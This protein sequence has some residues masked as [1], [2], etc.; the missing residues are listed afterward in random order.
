MQ[1]ARQPMYVEP[2]SMH[3][4][5][6]IKGTR[7]WLDTDSFIPNPPC[8]M[9]SIQLK[10]T[11]HCALYTVHEKKNQGHGYYVLCNLAH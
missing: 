9:H 6:K 8:E 7:I 5:S 10:W 11:V 3:I 1:Q 2:V 4:N